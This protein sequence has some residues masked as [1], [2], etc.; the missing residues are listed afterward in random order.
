MKLKVFEHKNIT[1]HLN[2]EVESSVGTLGSFE[3][4]VRANGSDAA[5]YLR[6]G[7][8]IMATGVN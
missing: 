1:V 8:V 7:A 3:T 6:H 4:K 2:S 5:T